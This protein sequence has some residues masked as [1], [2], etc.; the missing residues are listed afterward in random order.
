MVVRSAEDVWEENRKKE[1]AKNQANFT[2][3]IVESLAKE[4]GHDPRKIFELENKKAEVLM[5]EIKAKEERIDY[6]KRMLK[7]NRLF[8][9]FVYLI[10]TMGG[11]WL[12]KI[13]S[14]GILS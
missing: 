4:L 11:I 9:W 8:S 10:L 14:K 2:R 3:G 12:L 1:Q 6:E 5:K 7:R 13:F